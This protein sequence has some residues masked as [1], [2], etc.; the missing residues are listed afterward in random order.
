M[1]WP[2]KTGLT[3]PFA[4]LPVS[5]DPIT[6]HITEEAGITATSEDDFRIE[7]LVRE[8][9]RIAQG[10]PVLRSRRQ[11]EIVM[12][13]P[14]P[15]RVAEIDL[16]PG[17]R[18]SRIIFFHEQD[19]GRHEF[20]T[21]SVKSLDDPDVVRKALLEAGL[22]PLIR[23][24][25]FGRMPA[26]KE[27]PAAIVVMALDT[28]PGAPDPRL[29]IAGSQ[30]DFERG[31]R[32]LMLL[33]SGQLFLC[34]DRG[35]DLVEGGGLG[36]RLRIVKTEPLHP[37]GLAGFHIHHICLIEPG[38]TV[39]DIHAEDVAAIGAFLE[40]GLIPET[41]LVSVTGPAL[42]EQRIVR[43]Q[44]GA[45]LRALSYGLV[46]PGRHSIM[47]GSAL[48][49]HGARWLGL[50]DRQ[51][52]VIGGEASTQ[53]SHWFFS[54]LQRASRP[55][56]VIPTAAL[57][58]AMGGALPAVPLL[59]ALSAGDSETAIRLGVLSFLSED[60]ALADYVTGAQPRHAEQLMR[61]LRT[62]EAEGWQ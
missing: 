10:A 37:W 17:R 28:R 5:S 15:A 40:T 8:D 34:Q 6:M 57:D 29:A 18:L 56:P 13:A 32:A 21:R 12:T 35:S 16:G 1:S 55:L 39:W 7:A 58:Q 19:A 47:T 51:T 31:L 14:M 53:E 23:S 43:S 46:K 20:D 24:R 52:A 26:P 42:S 2:F 11:P 36:N 41:R 60:L 61:M 48:D 33:T 62:I 25:P 59:R 3:V 9:D 49:G 50:R 44:P 45:D 54:A 27:A 22:W 4:A 38:K 30:E